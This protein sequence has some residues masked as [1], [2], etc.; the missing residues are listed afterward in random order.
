MEK[1]PVMTMEE[2]VEKRAASLDSAVKAASL[3]R[4]IYMTLK[5]TAND[6][7]HR[8]VDISEYHK[9]ASA[10]STLLD[11]MICAG[12][13]DIFMYFKEQL[14]PNLK[15]H[16]RYFRFHCRELV[17]QIKLIDNVR[18]EQSNIRRVK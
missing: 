17:D 7:V 2:L 13:G 6:I 11:I 1:K 16:A 10:L 12:G 15:G 14:D 5:N 18:F 3:K 4:D 8:P 9:T